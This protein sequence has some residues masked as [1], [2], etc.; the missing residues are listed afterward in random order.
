MVLFLLHFS[1]YVAFRRNMH[2][3]ITHSTDPFQNCFMFV[4]FTR[5]PLGKNANPNRKT[6]TEIRAHIRA[7]QVQFIYSRFIFLIILLAPRTAFLRH[8]EIDRNSIDSNWV[9]LQ[10]Y[11]KCASNYANRYAKI[12]WVIITVYAIKRWTTLKQRKW[13]A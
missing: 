7:A 13:W 5:S 12:T 4:L 2:F 11:Q 3:C 9:S 6:H 1:V 10:F 8:S